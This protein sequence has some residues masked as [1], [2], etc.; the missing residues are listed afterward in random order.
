MGRKTRKRER[1]RLTSTLHSEFD[2]VW[3]SIIQM[4]RQFLFFFSSFYLFFDQALWKDRRTNK[5]KR[6]ILNENCIKYVFL[7]E[8]SKKQSKT[9]F[10]VF[11]FHNFNKFL[12]HSLTQSFGLL[13]LFGSIFFFCSQNALFA[14]KR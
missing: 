14:F 5:K 4:F 11:Q 13:F 1:S 9:D 10:Q 6:M 2:I 3:A 8:S 7:G 12:A